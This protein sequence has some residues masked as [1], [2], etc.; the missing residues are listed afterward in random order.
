MHSIKA[1]ISF[2]SLP[3]DPQ[4]NKR[5]FKAGWLLCILERT[6]IQWENRGKNAYISKNSLK[7]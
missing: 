3:S 1:K 6:W 5:V 7:Y 2:Y 4:Y